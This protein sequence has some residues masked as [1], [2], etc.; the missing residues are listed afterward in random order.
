M[1]HLSRFARS[2]PVVEMPIPVLRS[3]SFAPFLLMS[4]LALSACQT[5]GSD[6]ILG[7]V[8]PNS[9]KKDDQVAAVRPGQNPNA[10][11]SLIN[12]R[13]SLTDYCPAVR[14]RAGTETYQDFP[15]G[16]DREDTDQI[17]Y[18]ATITNVA[19]ECTYVGNQ[20][21]IKVGARGRVITGPKGGPG[22]V[23]TP[24]RVAVTTGEDVSY[25]KLHKPAQTIAN[26]TTY[27]QFAFVDDQITIPAPT[28]A[29][30]RVFIGFDEGPYNTP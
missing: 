2:S 3:G 18:Q 21:Q 29:N 6:G 17:R 30:V 4:A 27:T 23:T 25:S 26:G 5:S 28:A 10:G 7:S 22:S 9:A 1:C 16:A 13:T 19:R 20:L 24:I 14:I 12:T 15:K 11:N 8:L